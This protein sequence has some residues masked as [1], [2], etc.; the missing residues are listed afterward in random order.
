MRRTPK[1]PLRSTPPRRSL[2]LLRLFSPAKINLYL[3]VLGRRP[4]GYHD[5]DTLFE[6]IS[7]C[8]TLTLRK[9]PSGVR[10]RCSACG[11]PKGSGNLAVKAARLLQDKYLIKSGVEITLQKKIPVSAGLGGGS[12]NA[13][14]ALVGLNRLWRLRLSRQKLIELAG[15][16]GSDVPFFVLDTPFARGTGRGEVLKRVQGPR[17]KLWHCLVKPSFGISTRQAYTGISRFLTPPKGDV[18][19]LLRLLE[20]GDQE[21]LSGLLTNS[22]ELALN[23]RLKTISGIKKKLVLE[24][25]FASLMSGSGSTV[26]GLF[27]TEKEARRAAARLKKANRAW[28][29]YTVSTY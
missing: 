6:R 4:D 1:P 15:Q 14:T 3:H 24:G 16:L 28:R 10:L 8:D 23:K 20:T 13:A 9:I 26:F 18:R 11:I 21:P 19:M 29:V 27:R 25:A 2:S 5:L 17:K 22:L 12:S 7:L